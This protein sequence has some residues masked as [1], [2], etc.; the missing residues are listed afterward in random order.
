MIFCPGCHDSVT[1]L[2]Y[3]VYVLEGRD[4]VVSTGHRRIAWWCPRETIESLSLDDASVLLA[5]AASRLVERY[6]GGVWGTREWLVH[7]HE[8]RP[9]FGDGYDGTDEGP[10]MLLSEL[11]EECPT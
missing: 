3:R 5:V 1:P 11:L 9:Y 2:W 8:A 7:R 10:G 6:C 4:P